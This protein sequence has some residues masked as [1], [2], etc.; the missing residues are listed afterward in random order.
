MSA[1]NIYFALLGTASGKPESSAEEEDVA[2]ERRKRLVCLGVWESNPGALHSLQGDKTFNAHKRK[3]KR[4]E[5]KK[6]EDSCVLLSNRI[7]ED[8]CVLSNRIVPRDAVYHILAV[9]FGV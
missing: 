4:L 8:S 7:S 1:Q 5:R 2:E 6:S 3:N 9:R